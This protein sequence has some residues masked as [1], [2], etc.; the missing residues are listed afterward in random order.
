MLRILLSCICFCIAY[1]ITSVHGVRCN[2]HSIFVYL[3]H[4][5]RIWHMQ[6]IWINIARFC[7]PS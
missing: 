1:T 3:S 6:Y 5:L 2:L 4:L 7:L